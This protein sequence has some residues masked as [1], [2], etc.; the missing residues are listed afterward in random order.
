[1]SQGNSY[2]TQSTYGVPYGI[3]PQTIPSQVVGNFAP[4]QNCVQQQ[5]F[6]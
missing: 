4:M 3:M 1:M 5:S 6:Y 2:P